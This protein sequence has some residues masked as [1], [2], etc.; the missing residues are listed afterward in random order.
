[1]RDIDVEELARE[2]AADRRAGFQP[3][4]GLGER[5]GETF[6]PPFGE[7][8]V[9]PQAE[10]TF[11]RCGPRPGPD[12]GEAGAHDRRELE[13]GI[14]RRVCGAELDVHLGRR[15]H[16]RGGVDGAHPQRG[17][18]VADRQVVPGGAPP[19]RHQ[20]FAGQRTR[21]AEGEV[22]GEVHPHPL[23]ERRGVA[24]EPERSIGVE[25]ARRPPAVRETQM[26]MQ[27]VSDVVVHHR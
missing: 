11:G 6:D 16:R 13:V 25:G 1:M 5:S 9:R 8:A 18:A 14:P 20:A 24:A 12:P 17:L 21:S 7:L 2:P 19:V 23:E 26:E 27:S 15:R 3:I 10:V 22:F 4:E